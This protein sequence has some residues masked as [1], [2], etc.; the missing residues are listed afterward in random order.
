MAAGASPARTGDRWRL[1]ELARLAGVSS[2]QIRNYLDM[3]VLPPVERSAHGYR[4]FT[5]RHAEALITT[6]ALA[7]GHG[8][9]RARVIMNAV[10][11][12]DVETAL[13]TI[14]LGHAELVTE[15]THVAKTSQAFTRAVGDPAPPTRRGARIGELAH[16]VG[17]RAPVLRLWEKRGLLRPQRDAATGYRVFD[18]GEQ[19]IA[20]L[21]AVLRRGGHPFAIVDAVL[22]I[23]RSTGDTSRA[24]LEL[25][26]R[27]QALHRQSMARLRGSAALLGYLDTHGPAAAP[28]AADGRTSPA[29]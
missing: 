29:P 26:R 27:D 22:D 3:G 21:I 19:R 23:L 28:P 24:L 6:R 13:A 25:A 2:Q 17:V 16:D 7:A 14:D 20:H 5:T 9:N 1:V 15:R 8:W 4:V 11:R 10:H 18:A 12:D